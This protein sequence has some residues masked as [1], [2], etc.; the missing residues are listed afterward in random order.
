MALEKYMQ[1]IMTSLAVLVA[2]ALVT[3][4]VQ[5]KIYVLDNSTGV[6]VIKS[7]FKSVTDMDR[8]LRCLTR[9][10][11][12]EA[13]HEPPEG[14]IAVAQVTMNR[15]TDGRFG[16]DIC[17]VVYAKN[18]VYSQVVCQFSWLC[19]GSEKTR[20]VRRDLWDESERAAK[21]VLLEG[22]KLPSLEY[23]LYFHATYVNPQWKGKEKVATIGN[24]IFYQQQ[25][26][27]K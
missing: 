17:E 19:D 24:H 26:A 25:G 9:N 20:S 1:F 14:K 27:N 3:M 11:Y 6:P 12:Y 7:T 16:G 23:A 21:K 5:K 4:V 8:Q 10:V 2:F 18:V 15:V 22:F 13:S